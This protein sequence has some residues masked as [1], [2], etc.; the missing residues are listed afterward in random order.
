MKVFDKA[1]W[2]IDQGENTSEVIAKFKAVFSFLHA[3]KMLSADGLE[4]YEFGIDSS[5]S[6][7]ERMV[8][9][10]GSFFLAKHYDAVINCSAKTI[11]AELEKKYSG[12]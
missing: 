8:T 12:N 9:P 5:I 4:M 6:L 3:H 7:N 2:H 1:Q 10:N 11:V